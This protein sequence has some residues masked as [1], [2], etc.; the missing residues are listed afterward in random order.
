MKRTRRAIGTGIG[1]GGAALGLALL[2]LIGI[3]GCEKT[4]GNRRNVV[5]IV[6]DTV[7]ADHL[8][9]YGYGR[10]TSPALDR[11]SERGAVFDMALATSPWT[12]P[13]FGSIYT[14]ELPSRHSA[15]LL[16]PDEGQGRSFV[17]LDPTVPSLPQ[18]LAA[19]GYATAA[20]INN[21]FLHP[22]FG[23]ARGFETYDYAPGNN[24]QI[25]RADVIVQRSLS[26]LDARDD[27]PFFLVVH[28]FDPHMNYDPPLAVRGRFAK[29]YK[30][31]L[32][33]P[34][35]DLAGI[36]EGKI[37]LDDADRTFIAAAYDEEL[38]FVDVQLGRL[39]E[40]F[41]ERGVLGDTVIV[42]T[43]DHGEELFDHGGFEHGY[44]VHQEVLHV[45][46][47][48]WGPGIDGKR[49]GGAVS[50]ADISPTILEA[51]GL[52]ATEGVVGRSLWGV[53]TRDE[54]VPE[55]ELIAEGVLWGPERKALVRW[56][57][58]ATLNVVSRER[59][60]YDLSTDP[61]EQRNLAGTQLAV[62]NSML[63]DLIDRVREAQRARIQQHAAA[64]PAETREQLRA[65]GYLD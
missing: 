56:P 4:E 61:T 45:P 60:L 17:A 52:P 44:S 28:F 22:Q 48:L 30:G 58:K 25:R 34:I 50:I 39:F 47:V 1:R 49:Y 43:S 36:R 10:P 46:L 33:L 14:G 11:W 31:K 26:W 29:D 38:L 57:Q 40:G 51:L 5:L 19:R 59:S 64:I 65:L 12:L 20:V 3:V 32:T 8:G 23:V 9:L 6:L 53:V 62:V 54:V 16:M 35:S 21:P 41:R 55:R 27:R 15:G 42:L 63:S 18:L 2:L 37:E 13:S 7:R 24:A